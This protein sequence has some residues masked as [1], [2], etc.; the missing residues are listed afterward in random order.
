MAVIAQLSLAYLQL[1]ASNID[2]LRM[3]ATSQALSQVVTA[4]DQ[5]ARDNSA[6]LLAGPFPRQIN[7]A[8]LSPTY[9]QGGNGALPSG[10]TYCAKVISPSSNQ[11][12]ILVMTSG[13]NLNASQ[14][15]KVALN[16]GAKA[17]L[18]PPGGAVLS[19]VG[20]GWSM[21]NATLQGYGTC[22][23]GAGTAMGAGQV[24]INLFYSSLNLSSDFLHRSAIPG[25]AAANTMN[26]PIGLPAVTSGGACGASGMLAALSDGSMASC[27]SGSWTPLVSNGTAGSWKAPAASY[28]SLPGIGNSLGDARATT[29]TGR[30]YLWNGA[31]WVAAAVDQN[32]NLQVPNGIV[33]NSLTLPGGSNS[34]SVKVGSSYFYGDGT[35]SAIRQAGSLSIQNQAGTAYSNAYAN[36]YW[37]AAKGVWASSLSAP[38]GFTKITIRSGAGSPGTNVYCQAGESLSG[39]S[40]KG[41]GNPGS[42]FPNGSNGCYGSATGGATVYAFCAS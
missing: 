31:S 41:N 23:A 38:A 34:A 37:I 39:C 29:D 10:Q 42:S 8:D 32:G 40:A 12:S 1:S 24:A 4:I 19:G 35:N 25:N 3:A 14:Q 36:D 21:G 27:Q 20:G 7:A 33:A 17:G 18:V 9:I 5:Y 16:I 26:T 6:A 11:L 30:I 15:Q 13:G 2:D 22:S 28:A